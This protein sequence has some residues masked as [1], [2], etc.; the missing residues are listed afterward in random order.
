ML[1]I[2]DF[3]G[4]SNAIDIAKGKYKIPSSIKEMYKQ[5]RREL[6]NKKKLNG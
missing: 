6:L 3:I 1:Q 2:D 5:S 4:K